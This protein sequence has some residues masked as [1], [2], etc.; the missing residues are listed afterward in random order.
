MPKWDFETELPPD[1]GL[2]FGEWTPVDVLEAGGGSYSPTPLRGLVRASNN[3]PLNLGPL[4]AIHAQLASRD[5]ATLRAAATLGAAALDLAAG[6]WRGLRDL[7]ERGL[8]TGR[9]YFPRKY[10]VEGLQVSVGTGRSLSIAAGSAVQGGMRRRYEARPN[11]IAV[12]TNPGTSAKTYTL[13][14]TNDGDPYLVEG[15][16]APEGGLALAR[17]TVPAGDTGATF[18]GT[19]TDVRVVATPS[20]WFPPLLPTFTVALPYPMPSTDYGVFLHVESASDLGR[21]HLVVTN[22]TKNAFTINNMGTADDIV[23]RWMAV[24]TNWR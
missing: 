24:E 9:A 16:S 6:T 20:T 22:K 10:V 7:R 3:Q 18:A 5:L 4:A 11:A 2:T 8:Q 17:V 1:S 19:L 15:T 21:V 23:V 12:P 13:Y 14:L